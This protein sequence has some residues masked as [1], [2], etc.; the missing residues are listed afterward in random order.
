MSEATSNRLEDETKRRIGPDGRYIDDDEEEDADT[1]KN[2]DK[3]KKKKV[4]PSEIAVRRQ[5]H[6]RV[7]YVHA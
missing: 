7:L 2:K 6:D 1:K 3:E 4:T 5:D